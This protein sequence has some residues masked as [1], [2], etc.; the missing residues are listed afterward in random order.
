MVVI[1]P[2]EPFEHTGKRL[3]VLNANLRPV[4][5]SE[6]IVS[7]FTSA[8]MLCNKD[9]RVLSGNALHLAH[10]REDMLSLKHSLVIILAEGS[11]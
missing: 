9:V 6:H 8:L 7:D 10:D 11:K 2:N 1:H 3:A 4:R 5:H